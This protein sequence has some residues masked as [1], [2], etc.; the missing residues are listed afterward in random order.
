MSGTGLFSIARSALVA[1]QTALQTVS[2]N[3]AN[4]ETPGYSR[5]EAALS[6]TMPVRMPYGS[7]GTGVTVDTILRRRDVLLDENFRAANDLASRSEMRSGLLS[8]IE[9][10]FGEPT[11]AGMSAALDSFFNAWSD[12]ATSPGNSAAREVLQQRG[13]QLAQLLNS[14][15]AQLSQ[16]RQ[17]SVDRL[18]A[19]ISEVNGLATQV[20]D[21]NYQIV[22]AESGGHAAGDLR[23]KRD[24]L[25]DR[26]SQLTGARA[27][28]QMDGSVSVIVGSSTLVDSNTARPLTLEIAVPNPPPTTPLAD[29]PVRIRLGNSPDAIRGFGGEMGAVV[30]FINTDIPS[31]R[32]RLDAFAAGLVTA[33]NA[34]HTQNYVFSNNTIPGTAAGN[35]FDPGSLALPVSAATIHLSDAVAADSSAIGTSRDPEAPFDNSGGLALS[36]LRNDVT[37]VSYVNSAGVVET[38]SFV[39]FFRDTV[40]RLGVSL[41]TAQDDANVRRILAEQADLR[42]ESVSGVNTDEELMKMMQIQQAYAAA[43]KLIKAADEML[44]TLLAIV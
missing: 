11:D 42:R 7:I 20:A 35:F 33:V 14:Y 12:L 31:I 27:V 24:L 3:I 6:V 21:L 28:A 15:D 29:I 8:N 40:S 13:R 2:H 38:G 17:M 23:D 44:Q 39:S 22:S 4:A 1:H 30:D 9:Q 26:L 43:T 34:E 19:T 32:S 25:V 10:M 16:Q 5:Q 18:S 36:A 41:R 37:T